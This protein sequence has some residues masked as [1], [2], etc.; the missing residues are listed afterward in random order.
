MKHKVIYISSSLSSFVKVDIALLSKHYSL[1]INIYPWK[2]KWIVPYLLVKQLLVLLYHLR[3]THAIVISSAGYWSLIPSLFG[4]WFSVPVYII[5]NGSDCASL[6]HVNYGNLRKPLL[7]A[8]CRISLKYARMLLPVSESLVFTQN[9][10]FRSD[11][12]DY[13]GYKYFFP[14]ILTPTHVLFNGL[15]TTYWTP[16]ATLKKEPKSFISVFSSSQFILK[17]G[18]LI[19][20]VARRFPDCTFYMAGVDKP[21]EK[22]EIPSNVILLGR[23]NPDALR[24]YYSRCQFHFQLSV[25]EGFGCTLCEAMLCEC[26]PIGSSVNMIPDIIGNT[27]LI[28]DHRDVNQL[29]SL[30]IKA[31]NISDKNSG[32]RS[33]RERICNRFN[34]EQREHHF[35]STIG[36]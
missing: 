3:K 15:D 4:R 36:K 31:L 18:D 5:L 33:A 11:F 20:K 29:E 2:T 6:P 25:F 23:L 24:K 8:I 1:I 35:I 19:T 14:K 12:T 9:N 13:Q 28:L 17:G 10:Y 30:I 21:P 7:K 27:G 34:L 16:D 26:I 22:I 32:A